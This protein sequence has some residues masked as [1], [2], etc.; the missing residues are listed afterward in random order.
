MDPDRLEKALHHAVNETMLARDMSSNEPGVRAGDAAILNKDD[1]EAYDRPFEAAEPGLR[2]ALGAPQPGDRYYQCVLAP[3]DPAGAGGLVALRTA[4]ARHF[5]E[6]AL[7]FFPHLSLCYGDFEASKRE[8]IAASASGEWP[9]EIS[10]TEAAVVDINGTADQWRI[11]TTV[12][13]T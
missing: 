10:C 5:G 12:K 7:P 4:V 9:M 6:S 11:V 2:L 1:R 3:V 13:L 8:E